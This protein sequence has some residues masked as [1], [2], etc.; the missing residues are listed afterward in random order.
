MVVRFIKFWDQRV[1]DKEI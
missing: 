1:E